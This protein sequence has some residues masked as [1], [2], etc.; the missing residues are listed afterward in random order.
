VP[1]V[2]LKAKPT[3]DVAPDI[4]PPPKYRDAPLSY[5]LSRR[6]SEYGLLMRLDRPVGTWLLLWPALWAARTRV[7]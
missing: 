4:P 2:A 7:Y 3:P 6:L 5:R 1:V